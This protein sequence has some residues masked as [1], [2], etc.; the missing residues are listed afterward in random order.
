MFTF[1]QVLNQI[2]QIVTEQPDTVA[3][4]LY[5]ETDQ[6]GNVQPVCIV[7]HWLHQND[8]IYSWEWEDIEECNADYALNYAAKRRCVSFDAETNNFLQT[9]QRHQDKKTPWGEALVL[10]IAEMEGSNLREG[11]IR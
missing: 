7:G 5:A 11:E 4:C 9:I 8:L 10:A 6:M 1:D 2:K 3:D